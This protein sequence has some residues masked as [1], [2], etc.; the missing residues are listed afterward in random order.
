[1]SGKGMVAGLVVAKSAL[2]LV[3]ETSPPWRIVSQAESMWLGMT[4]ACGKG[5][6]SGVEAI[7]LLPLV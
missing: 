3:A 7:I 2:S 6:L 4:A 5:F 1:M